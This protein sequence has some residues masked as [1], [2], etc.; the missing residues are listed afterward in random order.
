MDF[1]FYPEERIAL[2]ID[3]AN[4][5]LAARALGFDID[6]KRLRQRFAKEG[7]LIR[8]FYYTALTDDQDYSPL[9]PLVDWLSY[10]GYAVVTKPT[11]EFTDASGRKKVK[12]NMDMELAIDLLEM[13]D[14]VDHVVIF[15][16]D[17]DFRRAVEAAQ[18]KGVRV[19][20]VSTNRSNPP[21]MADELRRQADN[22]IEL[23]DIAD[24][25]ARA[26][27]PRDMAPDPAGRVPG[28]PGEFENT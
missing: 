10:N 15:S 7:R 8:A 5:Y 16:G 19:T 17:G 1:D 24:E 3:G 28:S 20:V 12:G 14:R 18:R 22:Y 6:F 25:I 13:A 26:H 9:R 11:K 23:D 27:P 2:F 4:L 21:M